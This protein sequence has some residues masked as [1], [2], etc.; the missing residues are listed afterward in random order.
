MKRALMFAAALALAP[1]F[2]RAQVPISVSRTDGVTIV[3]QP[4]SQASLA[5]VELT[6]AAGLDRQQPSQSGLAALVAQCIVDTPVRDGTRLTDAIAAQGG[7]LQ[8]AIE[9]HEV[10]FYVEALPADAAAVTSFFSQALS[11]PDF[12]GAALRTARERLAQRIARLEQQP[13]DVGVEMLNIA[14]ASGPNAGFPLYGTA[15][16]LSGLSPR[17]V[18]AFYR[19]YYTRGGSVV[20]AVGRIDAFG[21]A[22]PASLGT[23]LPRGTSG[24]VRTGVVPIAASARE[25][26]A[27]R[28]VEAPWLVVGYGAPQLNS[29]DY[30]PMLVLCAF[31]ERTLGDIAEVP[32][33]ISPSPT[34]QAIGTLYDFNRAPASLVLYVNGAIGDPSQSFGTALT[35]VR[36][37]SQR[38]IQ[39]SIDQFK[40]IAIGDF[41]AHAATLESRAWL[42]GLFAQQ[43]GSGDYLTTTIR[44]IEGTSAAD[45]Q[46]VAHRYLGSPTIALVLPRGGN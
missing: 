39:G 32:G 1:A 4:D 5:G 29:R 25:L 27:R 23:L 34:S 20:S 3:M 46:R 28:A 30:G 42:A 22:N 8:F 37:L 9:P 24:R 36:F 2:V 33:T 10:R 6:V 38:P 43:T 13:L 18:A 15:A 16:S 45:V 44:A 12:S 21:S 35:L 41:T 17:M 40:A 14:D 26:I 31:L 7:S 19:S 11:H